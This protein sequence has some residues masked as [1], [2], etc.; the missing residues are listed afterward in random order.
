[1]SRFSVEAVF[2]A[3]DKMTGPVNRMTG[4][5][6]RFSKSVR[7]DFARAQRSVANFNR[8][9]SQKLVTGLQVGLG[10]SIAAVGIGLGI[11]TRQFIEFDQAV[12]SAG[13]KFKDLD[14]STKAGR[15]ALEDLR[16]SARQVGADTQFSA[17]Q[18]AQGLDFL[19]MAGFTSAQAMKLLPG[20]VNI[21]TIANVDLARSTD[22]ASDALGAFGLATENTTQLG[23]NFTRLQDVMA[24]TITSTNVNMEDLF[25][26]IKFGA[27][28][29]T[30]AGQS[31]ETFNAIAGR[32]ASSG[33][34]G[35]MA[36]TA[37]RSAIIRLQ[38]PTKAV[39]DSLAD[40]G[41][42]QA[43]LI[44]QKTGKLKDMVEIMK[45]MEIGGK[46]LTS[47]QRNAALSAIV[48]KNATSAW[49]AVM[50]EGVEQTEKLRDSLLKANGAANK[51]SAEIRKSLMN[52]LKALG[53]AAT[54]LG[55]KF[56]ESFEKQGGNAIDRLTKAV[57]EFDPAPIIAGMKKVA[58]FI[59]FVVKAVDTLMPIL[60]VFTALWIAYKVSLL[61]AAA[62][63]AIANSVMLKN[64]VFLIIAGIALLVGLIVILV[65]NWNKFSTATKTF[66]IVAGGLL[67]LIGGIIVGLKA[68]G[69]VQTALNLI[70]A[71]N[72]VGLIVIGIVALVAAITRL[73]LKW[74]T[75]KKTFKDQG[76]FAAA[77]KFLG[78]ET[79]QKFIKVNKTGEAGGLSFAQEKREREGRQP[80]KPQAPQTQRS[81]FSSVAKSFQ[82]RTTNVRFQNDSDRNV[83]VNRKNLGPGSI[84]TESSGGF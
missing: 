17:T 12:I 34:K 63:Q 62:A 57:R 40:L 61:Q 1:M 75:L 77:D 26:T 54:E 49:A 32:M 37:L 46:D 66:I 6:T 3:V 81:F 16:K 21:A 59:V 79:K 29:F 58:K 8:S 71:A 39:R 48:G 24:K 51:M 72:P 33:I 38:A 41:L 14:T 69:V 31:M 84:Q 82:E 47:V 25:E 23:I 11:V 20:V 22:I 36:G 80:I 30:A 2:S 60:T 74:D 64:P 9:I 27:P 68:W 76:F 56:I 28:S 7:R 13:A 73:I 43:D 19:A 44:N 52:R 45:L 35:S 18:A 15:K 4:S 65:K 5:T 83:E 50:N 67:A 10:A 55:F 78:F 53:S 42:T 70:M